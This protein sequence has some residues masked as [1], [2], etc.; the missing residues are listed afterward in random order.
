MP[1]LLKNSL[2]VGWVLCV[3]LMSKFVTIQCA[4]GSYIL[5]AVG[6]MGS[7]GKS[8]SYCFWFCSF[9]KSSWASVSHL[10]HGDFGIGRVMGGDGGSYRLSSV[11]CLNLYVSLDVF[12]IVGSVFCFLALSCVLVPDVSA[13]SLS[14]C[15]NLFSICC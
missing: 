6:G 5:L 4:S 15:R 3:R 8:I 2:N 1:F 13:G 11:S 10:I 12:V 14:K 7:F 9:I